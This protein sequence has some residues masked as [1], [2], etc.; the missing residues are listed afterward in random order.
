M[1][2]LS[3]DPTLNVRNVTKAMQKVIVDKRRQVWKKVLSEGAVEKICSGLSIEKE[4]LYSCTDTYV[5]CKPD[6]SWEQLA[7]VLYDHGEVAAAREAKAFLQH[8]GG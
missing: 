1:S 8:I 5:N 6:S 4:K 3:P 7:W 2:S